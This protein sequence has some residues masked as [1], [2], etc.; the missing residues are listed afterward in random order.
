MRVTFDGVV[1]TG[2]PDLLQKLGEDP[3]LSFEQDQIAG[4]VV[5]SG[6]TIAVFSTRDLSA[7]ETLFE[8]GNRIRVETCYCSV[9]DSCW[10]PPKSVTDL[11]TRQLE[12]PSFGIDQFQQL[13]NIK[14]SSV[15][16]A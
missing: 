11:P 12:C 7:A 15:G 1:V 16:L 5:K 4:R 6:E 2:W 8:A 13:A 9:F 10:I 14:E 3:T